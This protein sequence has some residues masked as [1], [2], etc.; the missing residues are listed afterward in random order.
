MLRLLNTATRMSLRRF[1][2]ARAGIDM[3]A[4]MKD[5]PAGL[6]QLPGVLP[7]ILLVTSAANSNA[8]EYIRLRSAP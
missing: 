2:V 1:A 8:S 3:A 5:F 4:G 6:I 7:A